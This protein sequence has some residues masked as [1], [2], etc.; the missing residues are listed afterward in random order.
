MPSPPVPIRL[1][2]KYRL[3]LDGVEHAAHHT[4]PHDRRYCIATGWCNG[5]L[6]A[7]GLFRRLEAAIARVT[8]LQPRDDDRRYEER[9][10]R[11]ARPRIP[12]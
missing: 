7:I 2:Q 5:P 8:G 6:E 10:R 4:R 9:Y 1:L 11:P 12:A 3:I